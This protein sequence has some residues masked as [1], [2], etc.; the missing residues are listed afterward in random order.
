MNSGTQVKGFYRV[1]IE[2]P[3]GTVVGDSGWVENKITN[4]GFQ[5]YLVELMLASAGSLRVAAIALGSGSAAVADAD[6]NLT[7]EHVK[8]KAVVG[9]SSV[10]ASKTAQFLATFGSS[11]SFVTG[12][13]TLN[14]I[15]LFAYTSAGSGSMFAGNTYTSSAVA[16]NQNVNVT[17]QIRFATA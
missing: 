13:A 15:G 10:I 14:N 6:T 17:Y 1:N 7:G 3:D 4:L 16:T 8:R 2:D 9:N 11:D 12:N 5:Y